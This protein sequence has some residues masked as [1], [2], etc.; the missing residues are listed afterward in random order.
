MSTGPLMRGWFHFPR[1]HYYLIEEHIKPYVLIMRGFGKTM[2][3]EVEDMPKAIFDQID[4][5]VT[6]HGLE[7]YEK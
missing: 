3:I 1:E 7:I 4:K 5:I 6:N 2:D